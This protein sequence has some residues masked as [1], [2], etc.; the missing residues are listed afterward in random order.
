MIRPG[1][2]IV[3]GEV[4]TKVRKKMRSGDILEFNR[5]TGKVAQVILGVC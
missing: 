5:Q 3:S 2:V 1:E 4:G